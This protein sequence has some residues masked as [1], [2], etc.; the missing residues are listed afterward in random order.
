MLLN[1]REARSKERMPLPA[2]KLDLTE[3]V[4]NEPSIQA[5]DPVEVKLEASGDGEQVVVRGQAEGKLE[6][7][8][9]RC[10][11]VFDS[12]LHVG[13]TERFANEPPDEEQDE[14]DEESDI[15]YIAEDKVDLTPYIMENIIL[16]LPQF[17][18]CDE[19]C[20]GLCPTCGCNRNTEPCSCKHERLDPRWS[21]LQDLFQS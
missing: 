2:Q 7:I 14:A 13:F 5:A 19:H 12:P 1:L 20:L 17:P 9:S 4:A 8:C 3:I 16:D 21:G 10:L 11:T 18:L 15:H 6:L